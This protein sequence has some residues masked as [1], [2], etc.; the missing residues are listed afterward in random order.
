MRLFILF[1][2]LGIAV[3]QGFGKEGA[4]AVNAGDFLPRNT[5]TA[6]EAQAEERD[7]KNPN[8]QEIRELR[9]GDESPNHGAGRGGEEQKTIDIPQ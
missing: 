2:S 4:R 1:F 8:A 3:T 7:D 5:S 9:E 6:T